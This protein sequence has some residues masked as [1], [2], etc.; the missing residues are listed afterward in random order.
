MKGVLV[1]GSERSDRGVDM[2]GIGDGGESFEET[3][4]RK[5]KNRRVGG[6]KL[7]HEEEGRGKQQ[8]CK[9]KQQTCK[10]S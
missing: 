8:T 3:I 9:G 1:S 6:K 7:A 10:R 4:E 2:E 5:S